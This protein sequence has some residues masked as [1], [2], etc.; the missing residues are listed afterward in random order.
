MKALARWCIAHRRAV[1]VT[2][3]IALVGAN[4]IGQAVGSSYNSNFKGQSS[5]G[6]QQAINLLQRSFPVRKGDS[7]SIVFDSRA[8]V[9]SP[10]VQREIGALLGRI[11]GF[12]HVSGVVSPY[13]QNASAVSPGGHIAYA[14]VLFDERSFQLPPSAI[15]RVINTAEGARTT[16]LA[17]QLGGQPIEQVQPPKTGPATGIGIIAAMIILLITFGTVVAA[18]LPL[19]TALLALGTAVG[20]IALLTHAINVVDFTPELAAM[21]GL[22]VGIDYA[23]F[24]VTRYRGGLDAGMETDE[25]IVTAMDTSGRAGS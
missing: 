25:A 4:A 21:I 3:V 2:W 19:L 14:T 17:I 8:S 15:N 7:A 10:A 11:A 12:P 24:V 18:G 16:A 1:I 20:L 13:A 22:G 6:S 5:S 9:N 23:L